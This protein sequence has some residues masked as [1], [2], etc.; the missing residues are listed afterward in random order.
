MDR[1]HDWF[2]A[3]NPEHRSWITLVARAGI[4]HFVA[5]FA[6]RDE[7][8]VEPIEL[9]NAAPRLATRRISLYQTVE[10]LKTTIDVM[11]RGFQEMD[12]DDRAL[13]EVAMAHFSRS[14][15]FAA[16]EVYAAAAE[17]RGEWDSRLEAFVV[18]SALRGEIDEDLL[19]RAAALGWSVDGGGMAVAVG[20]LPDQVDLGV[21]RLHSFA[22]QHHLSALAAPQEARL[23]VL[24]GGAALTDDQAALAQFAALGEVFGP[25]PLVVGPVVAELTAAASSARPALTGHRAAVL[26]PRAPRPTLASEL[27]AERVLV[28]DAAAG[29]ELVR[30]T[31]TPLAAGGD[32][33]ATLAAYLEQGDSV[34]AT[35]RRLYVHPNT[36]RYRLRR[37]ARLSGLDP[38]AAPDAFVL[39][40]A[41]RLSR[42]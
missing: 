38:A 39:N 21:D 36:V 15:A 35:A 27:L 28:G 23:V 6:D 32:L 7:Q 4:D 25:G 31:I 34:E 16:A 2:R 17:Q 20:G 8:P 29:A 24:L 40:V 10:L 33:V 3:M 11:E 22:A 18:D 26:A 12:P 5:W 1:R 9:F 19:S 37:I 42:L 41:L 13:L 14:V 30:R